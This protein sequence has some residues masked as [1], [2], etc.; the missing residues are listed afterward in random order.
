VLTDLEAKLLKLCA[1][2]ADI[3][4]SDRANDK[5]KTRLKKLGYLVFER[6]YW[7][8]RIT[9]AGRSALSRPHRSTPEA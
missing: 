8:W 3:K 6:S 9:D 2:G 5:A 1:N 4:D 7:R